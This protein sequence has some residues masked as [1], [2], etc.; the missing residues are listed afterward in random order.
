[1][2]SRL[3]VTVI[4]L[5]ISLAAMAQSG[6]GAGKAPSKRTP[7]S[8]SQK[9][10]EA[11]FVRSDIEQAKRL[12][13]AALRRNAGDARALFVRMEAAALEADDATVLDSAVRLCASRAA[14]PD[15]K[16]IAAA[17]I[18][19]LAAN[20]KDFRRVMPQ[21]RRLARGA[22]PQ[23]DSLRFALVN[24]ASDGAPELDLLLQSRDSGLLTDWKIVGPLGKRPHA[25]FDRKFEPE[26]DG[27]NKSR[28]GN[29]RSEFFQ[30]ANGKV[31]LPE[32]M[33]Q[34]G[35]FYAAA[36]V[37]V[38]SGG[39]WRVRVES[40]G[41]LQVWIDGRLVVT[42]DDRRRAQPEV[43]IQP[44]HLSLGTH[45]VLVKFVGTAAPFRVAIMAPSG[46]LRRRNNKP[47]MH[48]GPESE[49]VMASLPHWRG[50]SVEALRRLTA[51]AATRSSTSVQFALA[52]AWAG[53][54]HQ[55]EVGTEERFALTSALKLAPSATAVRVK[56]ASH[57]FDAE[58]N[59]EAIAQ[60]KEALTRAPK[61]ERALA[62][63]SRVA[64]RM[65]W[66]AEAIGAFDQL[67]RMHPSCDTVREAALYF[68]SAQQFRRATALEPKMAGCAPASLTLARWLADAGRHNEAAD[69]ASR[70]RH[71]SKLN[72]DAVALE[73][74]ERA[75]A[76]EQ[77][78][79][80]Q[81]AREL[82]D[83]APNSAPFAAL[84]KSYAD[85]ILNAQPRAEGFDTESEFFAKYRRDGSALVRD[86]A[87]R[88]YSGGP[89]VLLLNDKV[90]MLREDGSGAVYV[91]KITRVLNR[92]GIVRHGEVK[93]P[94]G[95]RLLE[96]RTI[97]SDLTIAEPEFHQHKATI[98]MPA[99]APGDAIEQEYVIPFSAPEALIS[100]AADFEFTFGSFTEP[101][102][103]SRF[104]L[105]SPAYM[106]VSEVNGAP[107]MKSSA[108]VD[109]V[110]TR[111]WE[112]NEI[113][114]F[115]QEPSLPKRALLATVRPETP[116]DETAMIRGNAMEA[117][118]QAS[119]VGIRAEMVAKKPASAHGRE[120]D[121]RETA[122]AA[123]RYVTAKVKPDN[124]S[125]AKGEVTDAEESLASG[126]GSRTA[127]LLAVARAAGLNADLAMARSAGTSAT[128]FNKPLVLFRFSTGDVVVDAE[129]DGMPFGA[130]MPDVDRSKALQFRLSALG[131]QNASTLAPLPPSTFDE[132]SVAQAEVNFDRT[133]TFTARVIITM[134]P[135]RG[136]QM[137]NVL[138][139][140][141]PAER[142]RF[143]EQLAMRLFAGATGT[144]GEVRNELDAD[145]P[146]TIT[147]TCRSPHYL[148]F[149][150]QQID[151]D[152]LAPAL[153]LRRMYA[154]SAQRRF[155]MYI[156]SLLFETSTFRVRLPEGVKVARTAP[157]FALTTEFGSYGVTFRLLSPSELEIRR[158]FYIPTQVIETAQYASFSSF[159]N[160]IEDAERQRLT[161]EIARGSAP[162]ASV[163]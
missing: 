139:G 122:R 119:R 138:R 83:L 33:T 114:Q 55:E 42:R 41:T 153:G 154:T 63:L 79:A 2:R 134:S 47:M 59:D 66:T 76:G 88:T 60:L 26:T 49:Y 85:G 112:Q 71:K 77:I 9:A 45:R 64:V 89:A 120:N 117:V 156:D 149:S 72:R 100:H 107:T 123:L 84:A 143:Y 75:L 144:A 15:V 38:R 151:I 121:E 92:D 147:V 31:L 115:P 5:C 44:Q 46:G 74:R 131:R 102:L 32:Y 152:Q 141:A 163:R 3:I 86:A 69:E 13:A 126:E 136:A 145:Q 157:D 104:V 81:L 21:V 108:T 23:S 128:A 4:T 160:Q 103:Y 87:A 146:L 161:L 135:W 43:I 98:S 18:R 8:Q 133:G 90:S 91:H 158:E 35:V 80:Q 56:L 58:R 48:A 110:L 159:A 67:A 16:E 30:F 51:L 19:D 113:A 82:A 14:G 95:A 155:P 124:S 27:L 6:A 17:R 37:S 52:N 142:P 137:R 99:L 78:K 65:N 148:D 140:I 116:E 24:A 53:S 61:S 70:V 25:D 1:M 12:A 96:L 125:F 101:I 36:D 62:L 22:G 68:S 127:T 10:S 39:E 11:L 105:I 118:L 7:R 50:D 129:M 97:K 106:R 132:R 73:M 54:S 94:Q 20:T 109:G 29:Q 93:I 34:Q 130:T 57:A 40:A 111:V 150:R 28:Y 162:A